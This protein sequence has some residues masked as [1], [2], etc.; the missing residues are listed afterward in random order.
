MKSA[1]FKLHA[2]IEETHWWFLGRRHIMREVV[3]Q[4]LPQAKNHL[5]VDV[6]CGTG[7]NLAALMPDYACAGIDMSPEAVQLARTRFPQAQFVCGSIPDDLKDLRDHASLF[8]LMDVLEHVPDDFL[9]L[10]TLFSMMRPGAY[11][12]ITVP[13]HMALW[14]QHDVSFGHYRR[15]DAERLRQVW[16]GLPV[17]TCLLSYYNARLYP[18]VKAVRMVN[19]LRGRTDGMAGTDFIVPPHAGE[20]TVDW[21]LR[22]R[23]ARVG[24]LR[25]R[26]AAS[27]I[28]HR[29]QPG[30]TPAQRRR[31]AHPTNQ[32]SQHPPGCAYTMILAGDN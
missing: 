27:R 15:Y 11:V 28:R 29:R 5:V 16:A 20:P 13:A 18:I 26:H 3:R 2:S 4:A 30:R 12:F 10:S 21:H 1:Q 22:Q 9:L 24:G 25:R 8:L 6:G 17:T 14:T 32:A 7:G 31:A 23:S 19:R